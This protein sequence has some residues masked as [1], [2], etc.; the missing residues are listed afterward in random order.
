[1]HEKN[2]K[3][4]KIKMKSMISW[5]KK[6]YRLKAT[7]KQHLKVNTCGKEESRRKVQKVDVT[8]RRTSNRS[9]ERAMKGH[10]QLQ[11]VEYFC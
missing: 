11:S 3:V 5:E 9:R 7:F 6:R 10:N 8:A 4:N 1:M 2:D